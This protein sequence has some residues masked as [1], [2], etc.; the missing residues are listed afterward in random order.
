MKLFPFVLVAISAVGC[1][2]SEESS[3]GGGSSSSSGGTLSAS[4]GTT[5]GGAPTGP[6]KDWVPIDVEKFC[7]FLSC[8]GA[9]ASSTTD[10]KSNFTASRVKPACNTS[11][12]TATCDSPASILDEC[13]PPC[14]DG[15]PK[16]CDG[17]HI[18]ACSGGKNYV[19]DCE[20]V[21]AIENRKWSGTCGKTYPNQPPAT[22]E[23]CWCL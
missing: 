11:L 1:G 2:G 6:T 12:A 3:S 15:G 10:C 5:D 18:S 17:S 21:C 4:G 19:V 13:F 22:E 9:A 23:K 16:T 20:G 7:S 8:P 14:S